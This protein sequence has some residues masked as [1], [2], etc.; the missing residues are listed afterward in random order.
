M[1]H[2]SVLDIKLGKRT[3][4]DDASPEKQHSMKQKALASTTHSLGFR[5]SGMKIYNPFKHSYVVFDKIRC[6]QIS[7]APAQVTH[8]FQLAFS[9]APPRLRSLCLELII[10]GLSELLEDLQ[11]L[12]ATLYSSSLLIAFCEAP[13]GTSAPLLRM[14]IIDFAHSQWEDGQAVPQDYLEGVSNLRE[15]L[16]QLIS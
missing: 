16:M 2:P 5:I 9:L 13:Q 6:R 14:K 3:F 7:A 12:H 8:G 10:S 1:Q 15:C 4:A 11:D